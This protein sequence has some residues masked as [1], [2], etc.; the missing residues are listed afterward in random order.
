MTENKKD[1]NE[2]NPTMPTETRSSDK[3]D[4]TKK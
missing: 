1:M 3:M 4:Q 2:K